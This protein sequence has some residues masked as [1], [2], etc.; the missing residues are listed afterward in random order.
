MARC[1][2]LDSD[3]KQCTRQTRIVKA[4][5][6]DSEMYGFILDPNRPASDYCDLATWVAVP[7]CKPHADAF[8]GCDVKDGKVTDDY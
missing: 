4:L 1:S 7:L 5:H 6:L 2:Y 3:G 8:G